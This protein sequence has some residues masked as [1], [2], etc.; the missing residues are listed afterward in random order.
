MRFMMFVVHDPA[1]EPY[2]P[3]QDNIAEWVA[4]ATARGARLWGSSRR[5]NA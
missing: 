4:D 1:A 2:V 3:E 5:S